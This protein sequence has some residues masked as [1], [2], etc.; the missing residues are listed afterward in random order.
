M[1]LP[2]LR[3]PATLR[4]FN[5]LRCPHALRCLCTLRCHS[6]LHCLLTLRRFNNHNVALLHYI[7]ILYYIALLHYVALIHDV[8]LLHYAACV[9]YVVPVHYVVEPTFP[10]LIALFHAELSPM[11]NLGNRNPRGWWKGKL[12]L[13]LGCHHQ[14]ASALNWAAVSDLRNFTDSSQNLG[15]KANYLFCEESHDR[16]T[17]SYSNLHDMTNSV[18]L[19]LRSRSASSAAVVA[20]NR[21]QSVS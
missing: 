7:V 8:A 5:A 16:V 2:I 4:R 21:S 11:G 18:F 6:T 12:R 9:L 1:C 14:N 17:F 10:S 3:C 20:G 15:A 13:P 19:N